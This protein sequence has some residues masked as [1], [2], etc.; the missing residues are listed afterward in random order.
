MDD[1]KDF[2]WLVA[3]MFG[4]FALGGVLVCVAHVVDRIYPEP[5]STVAV[6]KPR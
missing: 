2:R 1:D 3:C 6:E 5:C 4:F